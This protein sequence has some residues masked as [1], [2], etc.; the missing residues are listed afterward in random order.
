VLSYEVGQLKP[1]PAIYRAALELAGKCERAIFIDDIKVNTDAAQVFGIRGIHFQSA[2]QLKR[3]LLT[4][5]C[6]L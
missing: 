5:G 3:D 1:H 2:E 6:R 4:L